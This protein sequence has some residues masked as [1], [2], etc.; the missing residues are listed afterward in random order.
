LKNG[1][2]PDKR[3]DDIDHLGNRRVR[4]VRGRPGTQHHMGLVP[5]AL[6]LGEGAEI[7]QPM[8]I[9]VIGGLSVSTLLTLIVI[10]V[11]YSVFDR[12]RFAS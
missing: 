5:M 1:A 8:A 12:K 11:V 2:D 6:G 9:T 4:A 10:P 3:V 7:R